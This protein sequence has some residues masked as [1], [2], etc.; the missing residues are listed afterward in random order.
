M[1]SACFM[2]LNCSRSTLTVVST[3]APWLT[4][5]LPPEPAATLYSARAPE[6]TT[7]SRPAR[8]LKVSLVPAPPEAAALATAGPVNVR[9]PPHSMS[10]RPC[11]VSK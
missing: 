5:K 3:S 10:A 1:S 6:Y 8:P 11:T 7:V 2:L 4:V 9:V